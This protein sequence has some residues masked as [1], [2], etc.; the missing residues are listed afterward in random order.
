MKLSL[1]PLPPRSEKPCRWVP[2]EG[3][4]W[5]LRDE[6]GALAHLEFRSSGGSL[7]QGTTAEG[8][9][10]FKRVGFFRPQLTVRVAGATADL[11]RMEFPV[12]GPAI[13]HWAD[14][15]QHLWRAVRPAGVEA[16]QLD[17]RFRRMVFARSWRS[18]GGALEGETEWAYLRGDPVLLLFAWYRLVLESE[19]GAAATAVVT[20]VLYS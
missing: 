7:A 10:T 1:R 3:R 9:W 13:L 11:A 19:D 5:L 6:E 18:Q 14:G 12:R 8:L 4:A 20:A 15:R 16:G 17:R 2:E